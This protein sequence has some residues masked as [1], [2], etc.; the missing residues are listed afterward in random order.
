[1]DERGTGVLRVGEHDLLRVT[2][3]YEY[4]LPSDLALRR[5]AYGGAVD[6]AECA[7]VD[8]GQGYDLVESLDGDDFKSV[9]VEP[10]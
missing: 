5:E 7:L 1:M 8:A 10:V 3:V 9:T 6:P 2:V 4:A